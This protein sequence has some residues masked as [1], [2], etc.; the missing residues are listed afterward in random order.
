M[1]SVAALRLRPVTHIQHYVS[2]PDGKEKH[3]RSIACYLA[4]HYGPDD[5]RP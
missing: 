2:D 5:C 4:D 3:I 1:C